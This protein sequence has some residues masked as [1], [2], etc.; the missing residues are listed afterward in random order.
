MREQQHPL[1]IVGLKDESR[2][3]LVAALQAYGYLPIVVDSAPQALTYLGQNSID[4][5]ILD[6][7]SLEHPAQLCQKI[8]QLTNAPIVF[9]L[10]SHRLEILSSSG[11]NDVDRF[12]FSPFNVLEVVAHVQALLRRLAW[13]G[14]HEIHREGQVACAQEG[15]QG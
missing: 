3:S 15:R 1:L 8:R 10:S 13:P 5:I 4:L 2:T 7:A 9:L 11:A 14:K 12:I 6:G